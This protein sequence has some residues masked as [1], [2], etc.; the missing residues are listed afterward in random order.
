MK[1]KV[2][3]IYF[4]GERQESFFRKS[5][6]KKFLKYYNDFKQLYDEVYYRREFIYV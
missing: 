2:Y 4:N 5:Q 3:T 6:A 1:I